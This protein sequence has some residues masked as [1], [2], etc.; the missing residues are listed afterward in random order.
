MKPIEI[1]LEIYRICGREEGK[2]KLG[3]IETYSQ[4]ASNL[5]TVLYF[6]KSVSEEV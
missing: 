6:L 4:L 5:K 2:R 1:I 3:K